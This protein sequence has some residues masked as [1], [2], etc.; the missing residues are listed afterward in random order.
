MFGLVEHCITAKVLEV[1]PDHWLGDQ[2]ALEA[3][4]RFSD[5]EKPSDRDD[6]PMEQPAAYERALRPA[7]DTPLKRQSEQGSQSSVQRQTQPATR[8]SLKPL[9]Q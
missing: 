3:L 4:V 9:R 8:H 6:L 1:S 7:L 2:V 5:K